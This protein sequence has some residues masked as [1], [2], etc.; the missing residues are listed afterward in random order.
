MRYIFLYISFL[1][2]SAV[3][4]QSTGSI[5]GSVADNADN[6]PLAYAS[7]VLKNESGT[8]LSGTI[9]DG[10]GGFQFTELAAGTY[11]LEI[12]FIGYSTQ[13]IP[14]GLKA[15]QKVK[16]P[17]I[18]LSENAE[19]LEGVTITG[20]K[21]TVEQRLDRKVVNVGNDL[22]SQ[23]P[24]AI[25]LMNNLPSV[26]IGSDGNI[27]FR[28]SDNVRILIDG[29]LS[30]LENPADVLQQIPSN[31]IKKI[32]LITNP[33]AKYNPDG[34]NGIINIVLK[35]TAQEGWNMA[36]GAN[37]IIAQR[38][39]YN[40]NVSLN[41]KPN[42]TNYYFEYSNGFGDQITDGLLNRFDLNSNQITRNINNRESHF[43]KLGTD[44]YPSGKTILSVFTTQNLYNAAFDGQKDV[45]FEEN[46]E[47]NFSLDDFLTRDNH[48]QN[49]NTN[50]KWLFDGE[51]H[52]IE[53]EANYNLFNSD[54]IN[55]FDFSGNTT[56]PS[57]V[58]NVEDNR[59]VLT[60]NLDYSIPLNDKSKLEIGGEGRIN[61]IENEYTS[62]NVLLENSNFQ[63]N[64]DIFSSYFIY[65]RSLGKF[66]LNLGARFE[67]YQV[68][69][70]F[71]QELSGQED[72]D[73][74]LF[75][76]FP[77]FFLS[78]QTSEESPH[79]YQ[80]SYGRRI[81]RP[82]FRQV[83]P[84]RSTTTPQILATGNIELL[85]QFSNTVEANYLYRFNK[86]SISSGVFYRYIQDEIN[87]IG[88]FDQEDPNLLRLSYDNFDSNNA[89]G[90][91][92]GGNI[93]LT[94]WWRTNINLEL[95]HRQQRGFIEDEQVE[96]QNTLTNIKWTQNYRL[97]QKVS[98]SVFA[99]YSGPQEILQ[100]ELKPNYYVNAGLRY[101]FAN[102]NGSINLNANDILGTRRFAFRTFRTVF[103][104][105]EFL[106]DTQQIF[107]G[108]S[109]RMGG[110]LS[111]RSRKKRNNN[112]K[113]DRFL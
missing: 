37:S 107:L 33:S 104:A 2:S 59:S 24:S 26:N 38:E 45:V 25:D 40:S 14:V 16:L 5:L 47:S 20:E 54:L 61:R 15:Q 100:Y 92:I 55:D 17:T 65:N 12:E 9:T 34:L 63:Y 60:F 70:Q 106:R 99:F 10:K 101:S 6:Q 83:N 50:Y 18:V 64:R 43:I 53:I 111:S 93:R 8:V 30:N 68:S 7:V 96:V 87:R 46:P 28:G 76:I 80:L 66:K 13:Q 72:F 21:S 90:I 22:I 4:A 56:V 108:L 81:E 29:K 67:Q 71:D 85:P 41:F 74:K 27:S 105:G 42:K 52:F 91:E 48:T 75:N 62:T 77:S 39:R 51:S 23:G 82:S 49:Y 3:L 94:D 44:F 19:V 32:E 109:Y 98:A 78:Y 35:K 84:I 69:T 88:I 57:Y 1:C 86:G 112:I 11:L 79:Q 73:Q 97:G 31:S 95:Y 110:K 113:A 89:Y 103:Q 102:G 36:F 58:E